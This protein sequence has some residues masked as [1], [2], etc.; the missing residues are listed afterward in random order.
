MSY[1]YNYPRPM[2]T[3]DALVFTG[4]ADD[5]HVLL[6]YRKNPP[7]KGYWALPGGFIEMDESLEHAVVRELKEETGLEIPGFRQLQAFGKPNRDPRGRTISVVFIKQ[8]DKFQEPKAGDDAEKA[9]W[10]SLAKL[11]PLA[12]DH[13]K[14][15]K[16][17]LKFISDK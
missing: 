5:R 4:N 11:P 13:D 17:G 3:V 2:V 8:L 14:I 16:V 9:A 10:F 6:I 1:T 7:F 15:I 12:F